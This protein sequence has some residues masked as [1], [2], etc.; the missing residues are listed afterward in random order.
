M[1]EQVKLIDRII[2]NEKAGRKTKIKRKFP[3]HKYEIVHTAVGYEPK[4]N[5]VKVEWSQ[6]H[7]MELSASYIERMFV[8][9]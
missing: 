6:G 9:A 8:E 3:A 4:N 7:N 1:T 2:K 5:M